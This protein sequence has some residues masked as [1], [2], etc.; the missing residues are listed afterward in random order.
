MSDGE[1]EVM[2]RNQEDVA[3]S[4]W[5]FLTDVQQPLLHVESD[6]ATTHHDT[7]NDLSPNGYAPVHQAYERNL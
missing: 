1:A 3:A 6:R 4:V 7:Y 5:A 2:W